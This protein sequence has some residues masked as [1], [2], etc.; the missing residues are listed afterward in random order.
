M[1]GEP[2]TATAA[3]KPLGDAAV[4]AIRDQILLLI[5]TDPEVRERMAA[6]LVEARPLE[7]GAAE[8]EQILDLVVKKIGPLLDKQIETMVRSLVRPDYL[9][10]PHL[11]PEDVQSPRKP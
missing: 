11:R 3:R 9:L 1:A 4:S 2:T 6:V 8:A 10:R 7:L 5:A